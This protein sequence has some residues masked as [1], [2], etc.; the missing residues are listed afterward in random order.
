MASEISTPRGSVLASR[1]GRA[2]AALVGIAFFVTMIGTTLPTPLY[3]SYAEMFHI[4]ELATTLIFATYP[5]GVTGGLLAFGHWSDELGRRPMLLAGLVASAASAAVFLLPS[6]LLWLYLGR[7]LSGLSAGIVTGTATAAIVDLLPEDRKRASLVAAAV[8]MA[9]LG[10]GPL[11]AG[12]LAQY[13]PLPIRLCFIVDLVLVAISFG[14]IL[15]L[16]DPVSRAEHPRLGVQRVQIPREIR[17]VFTRAAIAGFAGFAVLGLFSAVS[18]AFL[19]KLL[20]EDNRAVIGALVLS[21][22]FASVVGQF[23]STSMTSEQALRRGCGGLIVGMVFVAVSLPAASLALLMIGAIVSGLGQGMSF[24]A[25]LEMV[26]AASPARQRG[27][28]TSAFF[29]TLYVGIAIPVI[30]EGAA[31]TAFGLVTAG[32]LF[33]CLVA[34]LV[35]VCLVLLAR[36]DKDEVSAAPQP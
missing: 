36:A 27:E 18:P 14:C 33:A 10:V 31:A 22:F 29:V 3:P 19:E 8:N 5:L 30:G 28:I 2:G 25:G 20:H 12:I 13:A 9:G 4:D 1:G 16:R 17:P 34:A 24:R 23:A 11:L 15:M 35:V 6:L 26:T 32:V 21:G 7:L